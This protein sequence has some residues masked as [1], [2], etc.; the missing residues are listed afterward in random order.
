MNADGA[1]MV[2]GDW[3]RAGAA[4]VGSTVIRVHLR[5]SAAEDACLP[6]GQAGCGP[7]RRGRASGCANPVPISY[8]VR[9]AWAGRFTGGRRRDGGI[10]D[11][12]PR[13]IAWVG[14]AGMT[15]RAAPVLG[16]ARPDPWPGMTERG[17]PTPYVTWWRTAPA[18]AAG[19]RGANARIP[20]R[21]LAP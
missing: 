10:V 14:A 21:C 16:R 5:S 20:L 19:R 18:G 1:R 12:G 3:R 9:M 6:C 11:A 8:T 15:G 7:G 2:R 13:A 4:L 17:A